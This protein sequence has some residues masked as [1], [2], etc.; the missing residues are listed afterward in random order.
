M[1][2]KST[3]SFSFLVSVVIVF[4]ISILA[5]FLIP[6]ICL[7][8]L[9]FVLIIGFLL[10]FG[11]ILGFSHLYIQARIKG[12][13]QM[14]DKS[15]EYV[16]DK[17]EKRLAFNEVENEVIDWASNR[18]DEID[19]LK[20]NEE[21]RKEFIGNLAHELKTPVFSVQ[22]Y[23]LTLLEGG[24]EDETI[25]RKFLMKAS[26]GIDRI[27]EVIEDMD[28]ITRIESGIL[29]LDLIRFDAIELV[30]NVFF[31][32]EEN[33]KEKN[34]NLLIDNKNGPSVF[35]KGDRLK[36]SQVFYNLITNSI[37][38]GNE[39]GNTTIIIKPIKDKVLFTI[40]DD[41]PGIESEHHIRL[42]ERFYRVEKSRT[43][44]K[45]GSGIGLAIV[46]H[47]IEAHGTTI[48]VSSEVDK[49][50]SFSFE[51]VKA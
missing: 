7:E 18:Q 15:N 19:R 28:T 51:L 5:F 34:I 11:L 47:I 32:L 22:G 2:L 20:Q 16:L 14:M 30:K 23:I 10:V 9:L 6:D 45:G 50:A 41:G 24:L 46:K 27:A 42:F 48:T 35:V 17:D 8:K 25:N 33:A 26:K 3:I 13:Y 37:H 29:E 12:I 40:K 38:Y 44:N 49:G 39:N 1:K 31:E 43:R 4:T 36:L 21:Y